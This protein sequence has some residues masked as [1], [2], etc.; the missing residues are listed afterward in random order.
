MY[1]SWVRVPAGS[2]N[3]SL[4]LG[5]FN[6]M[7]SC[8]IIYSQKLD[9]Y[10]VGAC[11]DLD[12]RLYEDNIGHSKFTS[13]GVPLNLVYKESAENLPAAKKREAYFKKQN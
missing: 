1:G 9:K 12:R 2:Q 8:Y 10:Y 6:F 13:P 7:A 5:F 11:I 3:L 4:E